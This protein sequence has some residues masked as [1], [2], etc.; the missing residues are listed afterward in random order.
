MVANLIKRLKH[1]QR[2][3]AAVEFAIVAPLLLTMLAGMAQFGMGYFVRNH[4]QDVARE[5]TRQFAIGDLNETEA[6]SFATNNLLNLGISYSVDVVPPS[7]GGTNVTT[8][9][10]APLADVTP[11]DFLGMFQSGTVQVAV[12]MRTE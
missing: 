9:I 10:S 4:M 1:N 5:T 8:Q 3:T 7:G 11:F 2:G 6:E 12:S